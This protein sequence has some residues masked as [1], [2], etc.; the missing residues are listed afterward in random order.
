MKK[1]KNDQIFSLKKLQSRIEIQNQNQ[2]LNKIN[3]TIIKKSISLF[4]HV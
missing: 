3:L 4:I 1:N 2:V